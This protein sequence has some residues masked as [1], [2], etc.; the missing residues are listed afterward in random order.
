MSSNVKTIDRELLDSL[1]ESAKANN[2][3]RSHFNLHASLDD[4]FQRM[5]VAIEPDSYIRPHR[6]QITPKPES[7][8]CLRGRIGVVIFEDG[9]KPI[10]TICLS[11]GGPSF[12]CDI[13]PEVWHTIVCLE[14]M[15][16]FVEAKP[17]PYV[18]FEPDDF[19]PWAPEDGPESDAYAGQLRLLFSAN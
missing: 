11:A 1:G 4:P 8:F 12:G 3:K 14:S 10:Q 18:P 6:H 16:A 7:L 13:E 19:A 2:R 5:V 15:S 9:G 17:G